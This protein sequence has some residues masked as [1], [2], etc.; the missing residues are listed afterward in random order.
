[1]PAVRLTFEFK[2]NTETPTNFKSEYLVLNKE[3]YYFTCTL[4]EDE[5]TLWFNAGFESIDLK[6]V[7]CWAEVPDATTLIDIL[8]KSN[9]K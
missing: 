6:D 4:E 8:I 2:P 5:T 7:V 9:S 1:M 3:G